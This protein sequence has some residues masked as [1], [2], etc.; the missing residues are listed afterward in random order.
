MFHSKL[1]WCGTNRF[2]WAIAFTLSV[3]LCGYSIQHIWAKWLERPIT[4]SLS[5]RETAISNIPFPAVTI[6]PQTK[7]IKEKLDII[8]VYKS[9]VKRPEKKLTDIQY[10]TIWNSQKCIQNCKL[11]IDNFSLDRP[12]FRQFIICAVS[13]SRNR[14]SWARSMPTNQSMKWF[15][16]LLHHWMQLINCAFGKMSWIHV[17]TIFRRF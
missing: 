9:L 16:M 4:M 3:C 13:S 6:C 12:G 8:S 10:E 17:R 11:L 1:F 2:W 14:F 7:T 5:E 15:P